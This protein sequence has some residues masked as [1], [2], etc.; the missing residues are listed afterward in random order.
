M[1]EVE[2]EH[3]G[4][5]LHDLQADLHG[6]RV[7]GHRRRPKGGLVGIQAGAFKRE[8]E[9]CT[10][11]PAAGC[12]EKLSLHDAIGGGLRDTQTVGNLLE[13]RSR[14]AQAKRLSVAFRAGEG[15]C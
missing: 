2:T 11:V 12:V 13:S 14:R 5:P 10:L 15:S 4:A 1:R 8:E 3:V 9:V 6:L 7:A